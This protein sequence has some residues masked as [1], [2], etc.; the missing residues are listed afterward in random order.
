MSEQGA[1]EGRDYAAALCVVLVWG[2]NFVAMKLGLR[3]VTPFQLGA[4]RYLFALL[5]L[6]LFVRPPRL[7]A[8]WVVLYG[9]FQG[10]G[11]FGL[12]FL[13]L[14]E[15]MSASLAP[16]MLQMQVFFTALFAFVILKEKVGRRL[17]GAM[18]IAAL[19]LACLCVD[20]LGRGSQVTLAG[21]LL[22][23]ASAAMWAA[24]N[25][26]VRI[27]QRSTPRF[28]VLPFM[29]WSSMVPILPFVLLSLAFDPP[30]THWDWRA[31]SP[32]AWASMAYLGWF[33]TILGYAM[34]TGL[35]KRHPANRVAPFSLAVPPVGIAAGMLVLNEVVTPW[36]WAGIVLVVA[37]LALVILKP[38]PAAAPL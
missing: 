23:V 37:S 36:Q 22:S 29:V 4:G 9:L 10:V 19:G 34:W 16:V 13:A 33:A 32:T 17:Q 2:T 11:Q 35:L 6:L 28:D 25:I 8:R 24:S 31:I 30:A 3:E 14:K 27:A 5:P 21:F 18:G 1:L 12:L 7:A 15:G 26:V 20:A 38:R